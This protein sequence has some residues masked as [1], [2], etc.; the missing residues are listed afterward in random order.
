MEYAVSLDH[1][2]YARPSLSWGNIEVFGD[3]GIYEPNV[4]S[5]LDI[6]DEFSG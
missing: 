5:H 1:H 4:T 6:A 3:V 2:H